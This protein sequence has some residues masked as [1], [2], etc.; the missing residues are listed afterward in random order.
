[1]ADTLSEMRKTPI[2]AGHG[3]SAV[4]SITLAPPA[5]RA[6]LRA[7]SDA[8]AALSTAFGVSLPTAPK[9][10][11]A[12]DGKHAL[13]LGPDEWLL[14]GPDGTDFVA[15]GAQSATLHSAVDVSHRNVAF[16]VSGPGARAT[17][18]SA[19]PLDLSSSIF[20]VGAASRTI[21]GKVEVVIYRTGEEAYRVECWRSFAEYAFGMLCEGAEDAA[22]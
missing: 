9:G 22:R 20:P 14:I 18:A 3:G 15:L 8:L 16:V 21:F 11:A 4:A 19:C 12:E 13:W 2:K 5:A 10:T 17:L 1:M 6:S 7:G